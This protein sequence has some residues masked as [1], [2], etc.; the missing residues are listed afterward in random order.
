V[1]AGVCL[2]TVRVCAGGYAAAEFAHAGRGEC[3][4]RARQ[5]GSE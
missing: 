3:G 4:G 2:V 1:F 5:V